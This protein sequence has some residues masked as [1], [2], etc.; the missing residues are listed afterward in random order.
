M[1]RP[2]LA[3]G[4]LLGPEAMAQRCPAAERGARVV[5]P[6]WRLAFN[7]R[8]QA[9]LVEEPPAH[10]VGVIWLLTP[11]CEA[12]LDRHAGVPAGHAIRGGIET[13]VGSALVHLATDKRPGMPPPGCI[14]AI[15]AAAEVLDLTA[16]QRGDLAR[17]GRAVQPWL[18]HEV[19]SRYRLRLG[20]I[21]GPGHWLRVR[22]NGLAL[23]ARTP[24]ADVRAVELFALLHDS[25]RRDDG[26]DFGHGQRAADYAE[27]L[28]RDGILRLDP[29]RLDLL[30]AACAGH[31]LGG[32][33][34]DPTIG[35]CWDADRLELAR[36]GRPPVDRLLSTAAARDPA[37]RADA[38]RRG[39]N[40]QVDPID[41]A[42]WG[43]S[44]E[45]LVAPGAA[46][47]HG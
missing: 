6:G 42:D 41:A 11:D 3:Y 14:E 40:R 7:R 24:G 16:E 13:A 28:V 34:K 15:L 43:L 45:D 20:G 4:L 8:G 19:L 31:E 17:W 2:Y 27:T 25:R 38:W 10:A 1:R 5:V 9:T 36:L 18:V 23:A 29:A 47:Y 37:L 33:S 30:V 46:G 32:V 35:C 22:C 44:P 21:H 39:A 12:A 26:R